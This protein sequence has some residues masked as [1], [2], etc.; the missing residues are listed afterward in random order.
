[1][2]FVC[3]YR[4]FHQVARSWLIF[5]PN[6]SVSKNLT[7]TICAEPIRDQRL[8][9]KLV[10]F[11]LGGVA[12]GLV[13][14]RVIYKQWFS[15]SK[16][17][18]ADDW[19]VFAAIQIGIAS[20]MLQVFFLA[21]SGLGTDIW[22]LD[23]PTLVDFGHYFYVMEIL[24]LTLVTLIKLSLSLFYL[25]IFPGANIRRLLWI[26][27]AFHIVCGIAFVMKTVL[28]CSPISYNWT[29]YS[30]DP[31]KTGHCID[32]NASGWANGAIGVVADVWLFALPLTQVR[33]LKLHWKKKVGAVIMFL[34]G[35]M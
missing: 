33:K 32:I 1:M 6:T 12:C 34:T 3:S 21:P 10:N 7:S 8:G 23:I 16:K 29:K 14:M 13:F 25:H 22:T 5:H 11:L 17:L 28:Q 24:Y 2:R 4:P 31:E 30:G 19:I 18:S 20:A 35:G 9:F 26:T 27:V 15:A